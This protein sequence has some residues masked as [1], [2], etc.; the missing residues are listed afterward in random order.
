MIDTRELRIGNL[1][2]IGD[3]VITIDVRIFHAVIHSFQ[4]Y[5]PEPIPL[6]EEWLLKMGFTLRGNYLSK[7]NFIFQKRHNL[8]QWMGVYLQRIR[9][10]H[11]FQN[12]YFALTGEE[13]KLNDK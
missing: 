5:E 11:S 7:G 9:S 1:V 6:S 4:G 3:K 13:L 10:V 12:L 8:W 2:M